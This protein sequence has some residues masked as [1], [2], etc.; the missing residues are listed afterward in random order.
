MTRVSVGGVIVTY[1]RSSGTP[2]SVPPDWFFRNAVL[3]GLSVPHDLAADDG[4]P[5]ALETLGAEVAAGRLD[6]GVSLELDW[7][8]LADAIASLMDRKVAG[9]AVLRVS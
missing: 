3:R 7:T 8:D 9:K 5:T 2:G 6:P 4:Q 1:G